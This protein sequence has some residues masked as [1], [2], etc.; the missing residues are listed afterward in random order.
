MDGSHASPED[1]LYP[2]Y[3]FYILSVFSLCLSATIYS[4]CT[5]LTLTYELAL[6]V[7]A[8]EFLS[9]RANEKSPL[10]TSATTTC[11]QADG[12]RDHSV[13]QNNFFFL[14]LFEKG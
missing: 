1:F 4:Y 6:S 3:I 7:K 14:L 12:C 13:E 9:H 5:P 10:S 2:K 8:L 11:H